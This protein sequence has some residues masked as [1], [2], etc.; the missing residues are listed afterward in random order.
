MTISSIASTGVIQSVGS[1]ASHAMK[2]YTI[3]EALARI[4]GN[5]SIRRLTISDTAENI[6]AG[7]SDLKDFAAGGFLKKIVV[8][9]GEG[10]TVA[11]ADVLG[12]DLADLKA[13]KKVLHQLKRSD[14]TLAASAEEFVDGLDDVKKLYRSLDAIEID[15]GDTL[16]I[17]VSDYGSVKKMLPKL[18]ATPLEVIFSG[19]F[20][21][22]TITARKNGAGVSVRGIDEKFSGFANF[23][24]FDDGT[25]LLASSGDSRIDALIE[26]GK[27]NIWSPSALA[28]ANKTLTLNSSIDNTDEAD[29][30]QLMSGVYALDE[31]LDS[32]DPIELTFGFHSDDTTVP[33]SDKTGKFFSPMTDVQKAVIRDAMS[34]FAG[35]INV[36]FTEEDVD[37]ETNIQFGT[38]EQP[39]SAGYANMPD[40][41]R[42]SVQ[43]MLANNASSND[44]DSFV[45]DDADTDGFQFAEADI[46]AMRASYG[47]LTAVHEIGH[48]L[49]LKHPGNYNA[50]GGG[51]DAPFLAGSWDSKQWS[52]MSYRSAPT[53]TETDGTAAASQTPQTMMVLDLAALQ[54]LYGRPAALPDDWGGAN[55]PFQTTTFDDNWQGYQSVWSTEAID[56]DL[57]ART[58][59]VIVDMRPGT[60]SSASRFNDTGLAFGSEYGTVTAGDGDDVVFVGGYDATV[61]GGD[62]TDALV[63]GGAIGDW[64][65]GGVDLAADDLSDAPDGDYT[66]EVD[67]ETQTVSVSNF[68]KISFYRE[69]ASGLH[70]ASDLDLTA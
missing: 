30:V 35:I 16:S 12:G 25:K 46:P 14:V 61:D 53:T 63:L 56:L 68:E 8:S 36:T 48:A 20:A 65:V 32:A 27:R 45:D 43:V 42:D 51:A 69:T 11:S 49:G 10:V 57:S 18:G 3:E 41:S 7:M 6:A 40:P 13:I 15:A 17:S 64:Q 26:L 29:R 22:Y 38:N 24:K 66:R 44:F 47:W 28:D 37:A 54:F 39:A 60:Y 21:D 1:Y 2:V 59:D 52:V 23:I 58:N 34:Y 67:G 5:E 31:G 55:T 9:D 19:D 33:S 62:G 4:E 70:T 50:G